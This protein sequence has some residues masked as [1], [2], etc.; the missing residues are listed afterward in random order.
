MHDVN[1]EW[2]FVLAY[3]LICQHVRMYGT[4]V[5]HHRRW[6]SCHHDKPGNSLVWPIIAAQT[7]MSL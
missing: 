7:Q 1:G 4:R 2:Y 3:N 5:E 6:N